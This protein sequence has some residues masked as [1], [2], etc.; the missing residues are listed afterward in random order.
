[1]KNGAKDVKCHRW[2]RDIDWQAVYDKLYEPPIKPK[3]KSLE[4]SSNFDDYNEDFM[5]EEADQS[6][7][8]MFEDF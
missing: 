7:Y 3:L 6:D 8:E 4:D 1:M 2:F 5:H